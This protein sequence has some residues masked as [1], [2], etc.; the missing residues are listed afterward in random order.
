MRPIQGTPFSGGSPMASSP[1]ARAMGKGF[2]TSAMSGGMG[3]FSMPPFAAAGMMGKSSPFGGGGSSPFGGGGKALGDGI[4]KLVSSNKDLIAA[5]KD[6]TKSIRSL[7]KGGGMGGGAGG[8][9]GRIG[10]G[11][12]G[13]DNLSSR[14][15]QRAGGDTSR[16]SQGLAQDRLAALRQQGENAGRGLSGLPQQ[17]SGAAHDP[18]NINMGG[19]GGFGN[20]ARGIFGRG[21]LSPTAGMPSTVPTS[22]T[23]LPDAP[24]DPKNPVH[25]KYGRAQQGV[26]QG[27]N[28]RNSAAANSRGAQAGRIAQAGF[29]HLSNMGSGTNMAEIVSQI[30][31]VGGLLAAPLQALAGRQNMAAQIEMPS[32]VYSGASTGM[33]Q[34][35]SPMAANGTLISNAASNLGMQAGEALNAATQ[36]VQS[37]GTRRRVSADELSKAVSSGL[38]F[39]LYGQADAGMLRGSGVN[40]LRGFSGDDLRGQMNAR[41]LTGAGAAKYLGARLAVGEQFTAMGISLGNGTDAQINGLES[42][43]GRSFQGDA[44]ASAYS[45][46]RMKGGVQAGQQL[47]NTFSGLG[48]NILMSDALAQTGGDFKKARRLLERMEPSVMKNKLRELLGDDVGDMAMMGMG[49][50][51]EEIDAIGTGGGSSTPLTGGKNAGAIITKADAES[52]SRKLKDTYDNQ[53]ENIKALIKTNERIEQKLLDGLDVKDMEA[54]IDTM[55]G[56]S[57]VM[58]TIATA[59][60]LAIKKF[61]NIFSDERLKENIKHIGYSPSGLKVYTWKYK[62]NPCAT[63]SGVMA[64]DL[65]KTKPEVLCKDER[66]FYMVDY[67]LLDVECK[68]ITLGAF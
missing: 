2:G 12:G 23:G 53:V 64:Q 57:G 7:E 66:G 8:G 4:K 38:G 34:A 24:F 17:V 13:S 46:I 15:L 3:G 45:R 14:L 59:I 58:R 19:G 48:N 30:P 44:A 10:L 33:A 49:Y 26:Q 27:I 16:V 41:G 55:I 43:G 56:L 1:G 11:G 62:H 21:A 51:T 6:L 29:G 40:G 68:N 36:I 65:L 37:G 9:A 50:T 35:G 25:R 42:R 32:M 61:A 60:P 39:G 47:G 20:F 18:A 67:R 22:A 28:D 5:I 54:L 52:N 63:F 31:Y